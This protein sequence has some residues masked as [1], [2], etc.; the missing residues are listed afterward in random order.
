MNGRTM[1]SSR[2]GN[3]ALLLG[4]LCLSGVFIL[5]AIDKFKPPEAELKQI[6][7]MGLPLDPK[8]LSTMAGSCEVIGAASL[9]TGV[10]SRTSAI[11]LAAFLGGV[12]MKMLN[13]WAAKGPP[14][15]ITAQREEFIG[16]VAV[17][18]GLIYVATVGP[19]A[20]ALAR[21]GSGRRY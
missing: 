4:R 16:N 20:L 17:I 2:S 15:A 14:E 1:P 3:A 11:L 21:S 19:G 13:F 7:T 18:G 5:S 9:V 6:G 8:L 12:S 10:Y